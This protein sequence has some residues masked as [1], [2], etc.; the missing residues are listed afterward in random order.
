MRP[1]VSIITPAYNAARYI[2]ETIASVIAQSYTEWTHVVVNDASTDG[3]AQIV[4]AWTQI[5]NRVV[6]VN[7][8]ERIGGNLARNAGALVAKADF[9][10]LLD[11]DDKYEPNY[12][13]ECL[14]ALL[15]HPEVGFVYTDA[16]YYRV[17]EAGIVS[18][19]VAAHDWD[20]QKLRTVN[21]IGTSAVVMRREAF[22][23]IGGYRDIPH[24]GDYDSYLAFAGLD[25]AGL[26]VH[27][28]RIHVRVRPDSQW[29]S[30]TPENILETDR[31]LR[32]RHGDDIVPLRQRNWKGT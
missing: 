8:P 32:E 5:D 16:Y 19:L 3:T 1:L 22:A 12:L 28:T 31:M 23:A 26:P 27:T 6:L 15:E 18:K 17:T 21:I 20:V 10:A 2:G 4:E 7:L 11:S 14:D 29:A 30:A 9:L 24:S 13:H 25:I